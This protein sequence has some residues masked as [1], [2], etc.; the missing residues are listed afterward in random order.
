ML[1][2]EIYNFA[3]L[4]ADLESR[5]HVFSTNGDAETLVHLYEESGLECTERLNDVAF[6]VWDTRR[7]RLLLA[8]TG[9]ARSLCTTPSSTAGCSSPRS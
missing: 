1:N 3:E 7:R 8:R 5:G 2:G 9:W 6:A 4:R